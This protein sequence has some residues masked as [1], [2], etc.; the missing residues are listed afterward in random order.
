ML[1]GAVT[2]FGEWN[3]RWLTMKAVAKPAAANSVTKAAIPQPWLKFP[4]ILRPLAMKF[5]LLSSDSDPIIE[6]DPDGGPP[7]LAPPRRPLHRLDYLVD[8][9]STPIPGVPGPFSPAAD[10]L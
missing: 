5:S 8:R 2:S 3:V 7:N 4:S 1:V 10:L 9:R 6:S